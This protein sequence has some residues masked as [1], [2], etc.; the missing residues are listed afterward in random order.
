MTGPILEPAVERACLNALTRYTQAAKWE[1]WGLSALRRGGNSVLLTG[2]PGCG[3]TETA[4]WMAQQLGKGLKRLNTDKV[5]SREPGGSERN[6]REFFASARKHKNPTLFMDECDDLFVDRATITESTWKIGTA[7]AILLEMNTYQGLIIC[8]TN[9][10]QNLDSALNSRFI[11]IVEIK[12]PTKKSLIAIWKQKIPTEL[13]YQPTEAQ[14]ATLANFPLSGRQVE[15]AI[16]NCCSNCISAGI[17]P[18]FDL[19]VKACKEQV[20]QANRK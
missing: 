7:E 10:P 12:M 3:K 5:G 6:V 17:E 9:Y 4:K 11:A 19:M 1:S 14:L 8:A 18:E 20:I 15:N 13:P 2:P 16:I